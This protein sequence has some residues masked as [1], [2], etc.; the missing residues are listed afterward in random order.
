MYKRLFN[1]NFKSYIKDV[2]QYFIIT[3]L[4]GIIT[5]SISNLINFNNIII[6]M[7][8]KG[9]ICLI[10]PNLI[11]LILFRKREELIYYSIL[12]KQ[13]VLKVIRGKEENKV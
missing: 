2:I 1:K 13:I 11:Y 5:Y 3:I 6:E 8:Y 7:L 9:L 10:I 4:V 12:I